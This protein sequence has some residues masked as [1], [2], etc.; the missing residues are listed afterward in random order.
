LIANSPVVAAVST[1]TLTV[2]V[3]PALTTNA[4]ETETLA[5]SSELK[6]LALVNLEESV[7]KIILSAASSE[8]P[9]LSKSKPVTEVS[10][11]P[12]V[13][14]NFNTNTPSAFFGKSA[15][16]G[17]SGFNSTVNSEVEEVVV[18]S[19]P[20]VVSSPVVASSSSSRFNKSQ[21]SKSSES[22][23]ASIALTV[24]W[25]VCPLV[26]AVL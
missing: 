3:S 19:L 20:V 17:D 24:H 5:S 25:K 2:T 18:V 7:D 16:A 9:V 10:S 14:S 22:T 4:G 26:A 8:K 21:R 1:L 6:V 15:P 13:T 23:E 11:L 12:A